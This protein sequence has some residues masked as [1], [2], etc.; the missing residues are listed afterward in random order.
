[1]GSSGP[2]LCVYSRRLLGDKPQDEA[3]KCLNVTSVPP[4]SRGCSLPCWLAVG[5]EEGRRAAPSSLQFRGAG[6]SVRYQVPKAS[7]A[8][9]PGRQPATLTPPYTSEILQSVNIHQQAA[10]EQAVVIKAH[11]F[12]LSRVVLCWVWGSL[13]RT[14]VLQLNNPQVAFAQICSCPPSSQKVNTARLSA[15][16]RPRK[17]ILICQLLLMRTRLSEM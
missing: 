8:R 12:F 5:R 3:M 7:R 14:A 9:L 15:R 13:T 4:E 11:T 1:M 6:Q 10:N 16:L 2:R 17:A